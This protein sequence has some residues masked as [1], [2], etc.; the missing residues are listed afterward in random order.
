VSDPNLPGHTP[1]ANAATIARLVPDALLGRLET[2][3]VRVAFRVSSENNNGRGPIS[4]DAQ[5]AVRSEG[6]VWAGFKRGE[7]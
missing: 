2:V 4:S 6:D 7:A 5:F 1:T 3:R